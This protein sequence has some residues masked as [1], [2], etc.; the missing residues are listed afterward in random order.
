MQYQRRR[1]QEVEE[2]E[3]QDAEDREEGEEEEPQDA[4]DQE[5]GEEEEEVPTAAEAHQRRE[6]TIIKK[7]SKAIK[8]IENNNNSWRKFLVYIETT[9]YSSNPSYHCFRFASLFIRSSS[10]LLFAEG[11]GEDVEG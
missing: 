4:E 3:P 9:M 11:V 6:E 7:N 8:M 10:T 5:E 1:P 2:E